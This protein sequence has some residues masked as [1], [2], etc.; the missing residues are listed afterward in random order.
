VLLVERWIEHAKEPRLK[1]FDSLSDVFEKPK[2][3]KVG[4]KDV[5]FLDL[6]GLEGLDPRRWLL[7]C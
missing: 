6:S 7:I 4:A 5:P 3:G 1:C 2:I